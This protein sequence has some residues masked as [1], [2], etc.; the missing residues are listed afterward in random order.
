MGPTDDL[1]K[2]EILTMEGIGTSERAPQEDRPLPKIQI[3][4]SLVGEI[5][6]LK[7]LLGQ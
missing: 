1:I 5:K 7:F 3:H 2:M 6:D 4:D